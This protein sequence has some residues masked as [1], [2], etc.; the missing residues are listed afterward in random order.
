MACF[1][2]TTLL[3][4]WP[5]HQ[6]VRH[7]QWWG[8]A[9]SATELRMV[10]PWVMEIIKYIC[11]LLC[12]HQH[13][14]FERILGIF[15]SMYCQT[16]TFQ[17]MTLL[18]INKDIYLKVADNRR[19]WMDLLISA[20][21]NIVNNMMISWVQSIRYWSRNAH[22]H[23]FRNFTLRTEINRTTSS[24]HG[25]LN[26]VLRMDKKNSHVGLGEG[27]HSVQGRNPH[28]FVRKKKS[29]NINNNQIESR[30]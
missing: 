4:T 10:I 3:A 19:A 12:L 22:M 2:K 8:K 9:S 13:T 27:R 26:T 17:K 11:I 14:K 15:Y 29:V 28:R 6:T 16:A 1:S 30:T 5:V 24:K 18:K 7:H 23:I 20:R 21:T 25:K